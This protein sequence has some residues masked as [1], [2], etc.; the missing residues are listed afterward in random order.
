VFWDASPQRARNSKEPAQKKIALDLF[1]RS[2]AA[3]RLNLESEAM[4]PERAL[5]RQLHISS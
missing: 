2:T 4:E 5:T 3:M 1:C